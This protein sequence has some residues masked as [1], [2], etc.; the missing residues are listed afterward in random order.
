MATIKFYSVMVR[1]NS[2]VTTDYLITKYKAR[3]NK[4]QE[5]DSNKKEDGKYIYIWVAE[6][7]DSRNNKTY[8]VF[9]TY[10]TNLYN[11]QNSY[12]TQTGEIILGVMDT[13]P[14]IDNNG[15][16]STTQNDKGRVIWRHSKLV[17]P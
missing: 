15:N 16:I 17:A 3:M 1:Q 2:E 7:F 6:I 9:S 10:A 8:K 11:I 4:Y 14:F 13:T 5:R 12:T